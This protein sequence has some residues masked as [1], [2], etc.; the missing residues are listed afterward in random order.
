MIE[1]KKRTKPNEIAMTLAKAVVSPDSPAC[2]VV[3][4]PWLFE[5]IMELVMPQP[6]FIMFSSI[7]PRDFGKMTEIYSMSANSWSCGPE[8]PEIRDNHKMVLADGEIF[9]IG[10]RVSFEI[11]NSVIS[12][13]IPDDMDSMKTMKWKVMPNLKMKRE[14][15]EVGVVG[16]KIFV[17]GGWN[18]SKYLKTIEVFSVKE[19]KWIEH[20]PFKMTTKASSMGVA[21]I[22]KKIF[23]IGGWDKHANVSWAAEV[24]DTETNKWSTLPSMKTARSSMGITAIEDRFIWI[25]GG[26]NGNMWLDSIEIFDTEKNEWST[27]PIKL[28]SPRYGMTAITA[29]HRIFIVG[30]SSNHFEVLDID[31]MNWFEVPPSKKFAGWP[32]VVGF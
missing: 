11:S 29:G 6:E 14:R 10:G 8:M 15:H 25:L 30:G 32:S 19:R 9:I 12:L 16:G 20:V 28:T 22:G 2:E 3:S 13:T 17:I 18:G 24:L 5:A 26:W 27:S 23:V 4:N 7:W 1:K 31:E 21:V